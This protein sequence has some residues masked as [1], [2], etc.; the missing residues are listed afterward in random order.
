[1]R[2]YGTRSSGEFYLTRRVQLLGVNLR[3]HPS[4]FPNSVASALPRA[5]TTLTLT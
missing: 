3:E 5:H 1:M 2:A 4:V